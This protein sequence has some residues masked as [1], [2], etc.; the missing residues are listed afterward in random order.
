MDATNKRA[1]KAGLKRSDSRDG[2]SIVELK[3]RRSKLIKIDHEL[4]EKIEKLE[5]NGVSSD[6]KPLMTALHEYNEIK[7]VTQM[8]LGYLADIESVTVC[9]LHGRYNLPVE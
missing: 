1:K 8:V 7:D 5:K 9:E 6:L 2:S 4:S 3:A